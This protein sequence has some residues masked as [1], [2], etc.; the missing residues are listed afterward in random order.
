MR[1]AD[2]SIFSPQ[3]IENKLKFS[4]Y[5]REAVIFGKEQPY[6]TAFI[7]IDFLNVGKWAENRQLAYTTYTDL[8]QKEAV[9]KSIK[10][11]VLEVSQGLPEPARIK[12]F[13]ILHKELDADDQELTRTKKVR[14]GFI[15]E[16]YRE[17]VS[18]LYGDTN[19]VSV[20][21]KVTYRDGREEIIKTA[22]KV[23]TMF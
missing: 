3:F 15:A 16:K 9:Y 20:E 12:R 5:I 11:S 23:E 18:A 1:L 17:L 8:S 14:R 7:N 21:A 19:E 4:P 6:V 13:V 22:V 10:N 2:G